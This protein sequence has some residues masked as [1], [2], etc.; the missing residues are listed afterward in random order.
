MQASRTH[1]PLS[2][3]TSRSSCEHQAGQRIV[4]IADSLILT[5]NYGNAFPRALP[6]YPVEVV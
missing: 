4:V 3:P 1:P 6:K 5:K 2:S